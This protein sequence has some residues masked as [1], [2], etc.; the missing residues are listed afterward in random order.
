MKK[1][2]F[3]VS[4]IVI[5]F[6]SYVSFA[7]GDYSNGTL[8]EYVAKGSESYNVTVPAKLSPGSSGTVSLDGTWSSNK[9][10]KVSADKTVE[11]VNSL[12]SLDKRTLDVTFEGI[13]EFGNDFT[14][15]RFDKTV[16]VSA[17]PNDVLFGTWTGRFNYN[18]EFL[19]NVSK[20]NINYFDLDDY[21]G[22]KTSTYVL[23][24]EEGMTWEEWVNS[25]FNNVSAT[26][27]SGGYVEMLSGVLI[28]SGDQS[29][30]N[31]SSVIDLN[32][33]YEVYTDGYGSP[34]LGDIQI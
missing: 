27:L 21:G 5:S 16:S 17:M 30:V 25:S 33:A 32:I 29:Y 24:F 2:I 23:L 19:D 28:D 13:N 34:S 20:L 18:V 26:I 31:P 10:I 8:V 9:F 12:N 14:S 6:L 15:Q 11:L 22:N 1:I 4:L 7:S 3:I